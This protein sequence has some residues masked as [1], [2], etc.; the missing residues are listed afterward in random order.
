MLFLY[1]FFVS[2]STMYYSGRILIICILFLECTRYPISQK[3]RR[4]QKCHFAKS[5]NCQNGTFEPLHE[6]QIFFG[7]CFNK[8]FPENISGSAKSMTKVSQSTKR[9][10]SK[11]A[12]AGFENLFLFWVRM[13]PSITWKG[14]PE[15]ARFFWSFKSIYRQCVA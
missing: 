13:N 8:K 1:S 12:L 15:V 5:E 4:V 10:F 6:I 2:E 14:K 7:Q 9:G 3:T 11:K